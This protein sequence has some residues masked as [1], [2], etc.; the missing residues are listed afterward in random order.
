MDGNIFQM[1]TFCFVIVLHGLHMSSLDPKSLI[2]L[3]I[4]FVWFYM[5]FDKCMSLYSDR[6]G[7]VPI[8]IKKIYIS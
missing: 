4:A 5:D 2:D 8:Y 3:C 7:L 1:H 6:L